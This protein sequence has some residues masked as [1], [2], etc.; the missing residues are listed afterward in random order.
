MAIST[1][2][3]EALHTRATAIGAVILEHKPSA[4]VS[5]DFHI[6]LAYKPKGSYQYA[7]FVTWLWANGSF[8]NGHYY[9]SDFESA[10][11]DFEQRN[12]N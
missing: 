3:L 11:I 10:A 4:Y 12:E 6:V 5:D 8:H 2:T 7:E 1:E 9:T